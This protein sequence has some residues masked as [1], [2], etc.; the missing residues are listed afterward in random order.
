VS[1]DSQNYF[2]GSQETRFP[3][4]VSNWQYR[5]KQLG[6]TER[7]YLPLY[8][9]SIQTKEKRELGFI[10]AVPL[11]FTL[12]GQS[13]TILLNIKNN[14]FNF[15]QIN[16]EIDRYII[17]SVTGYGNDKYLAFNNDRTAIT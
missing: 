4:S 11:C 3:S 6:E 16:Y 8:M 17:D 1:T 7:E 2:A 15:N 14:G 12:P 5:I 10:K 13:A 9:R